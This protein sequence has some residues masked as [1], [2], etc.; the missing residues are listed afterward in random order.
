M[1]FDVSINDSHDSVFLSAL[2]YAAT[3]LVASCA[4]TYI[5]I[6]AATAS[7]T[8]LA[9]GGV[10]L[11]FFGATCFLTSTIT[12]I[13]SRNSIEFKKQIGPALKSALAITLADLLSSVARAVLIKLINDLLYKD[14]RRRAY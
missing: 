6:T 4:G 10:A 7:S 5:A 12:G 2:P 3:S 14:E 9:V 8:A 1:S 11:A 13:Y